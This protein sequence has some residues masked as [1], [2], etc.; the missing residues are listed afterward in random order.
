M[1][2]VRN[3]ATGFEK[4]VTDYVWN[5]WPVGKYGYEIV[6]EPVTAPADPPAEVAAEIAQ[7]TEPAPPIDV[8]AKKK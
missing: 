3:N 7:R 4:Y 5:S 2:N 6:P 1:P 8:A